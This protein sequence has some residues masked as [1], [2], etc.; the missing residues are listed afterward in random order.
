MGYILGG[1]HGLGTNHYG[2]AAHYLESARIILPDG[3]PRFVN[4]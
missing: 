1:G 4:D 2:I 3:T